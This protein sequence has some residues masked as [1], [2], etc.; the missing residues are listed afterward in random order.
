MAV[1]QIPK[2]INAFLPLGLQPC[3]FS[4]LEEQ[5][6]HECLQVSMNK[7]KTKGENFKYDCAK[8]DRSQFIGYNWKEPLCGYVLAPL[9]GLSDDL[10]TQ[11]RSE[12]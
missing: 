4:E 8:K 6:L 2:K 12:I 9:E 11:P 7:N 10:A 3:K 5:L 1:R